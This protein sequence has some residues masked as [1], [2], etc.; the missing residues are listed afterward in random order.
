MSEDMNIIST[1]PLVRAE[2]LL[3]QANDT[4]LANDDYRAA[5]A[6]FAEAIHVLER[7]SVAE[8]EER[9]RLALLARAHMGL[10]VV[11]A[12]HPDPAYQNIGRAEDHLDRALML[13]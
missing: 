10:F 12:R 7:A 6:N 4:H 2:T 5:L 8:A 13:A 11:Y 3:R 1:S 9:R